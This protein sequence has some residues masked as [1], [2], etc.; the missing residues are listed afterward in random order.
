MPISIIG[1]CASSNYTGIGGVSIHVFRLGSILFGK[2]HLNIVYNTIYIQR[3]ELH[4]NNYHYTKKDIQQ[5]YNTKNAPWVT[6]L[7]SFKNAHLNLIAWLFQY[8]PLIWFRILH[9]YW[10]IEIKRSLINCFLSLSKSLALSI[11]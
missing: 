7:P 1:N 10:P 3:K 11:L 8:I 5:F 4:R 9:F 2:Q 6:L